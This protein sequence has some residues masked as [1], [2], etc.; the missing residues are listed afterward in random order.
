MSI[1]A[2]LLFIALSTTE[3][4]S[5]MAVPTFHISGQLAVAMAVLA[6]VS[7]CCSSLVCWVIFEGVFGLNLAVAAMSVL[8]VKNWVA[9][10]PLIH[11]Q[12][13]AHTHH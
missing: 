12:S 7:H 6:T 8:D 5:S 10:A 11:R 9:V 13:A 2:S 4:E 3:Y 1:D